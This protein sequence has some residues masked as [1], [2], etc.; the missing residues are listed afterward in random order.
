MTSASSLAAQWPQ[1]SSGP[2]GRQDDQARA[3]WQ[4]FIMAVLAEYMCAALRHQLDR[5]ERSIHEDARRRRTPSHL[6]MRTRGA[7]G[8]SHLRMDEAK[9]QKNLLMPPGGRVPRLFFRLILRCARPSTTAVLI[10]RCEGKARASKERT[11][12][13]Q[14]EGAPRRRR[15]FCSGP[16]GES[17]RGLLQ[18][19]R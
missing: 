17:K 5:S 10:L 2:S 4:I 19:D 7:E 1:V 11:A 16:T 6:R 9:P 12:V 14:D 3:A 13:A 15:G 18:P 8:R